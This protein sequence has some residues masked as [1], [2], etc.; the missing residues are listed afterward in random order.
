[1][2]RTEPR[3][4]TNLDQY[5][6]ETLPWSRAL[7]ALEESPG[8]PGRPWFLG[9]TDA[10]GSPHAAGVGAMWSDGGLYFVSG[11]RTRK[12]RD[13]AARPAATLSGS[14]N[15]ID[16]VFEG[17]ARRVTDVP[18]LERIARVYREE[19]GWPVEVE[20]QAFTAPYT[21]PSGGPPPWY[22]YQ[23]EYNTVYGVSTAEPWGATR[24]RFR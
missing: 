18:T 22:L 20:G 17:S 8:G 10:D 9:V 4:T 14:L 2:A 24:W 13:L 5:G 11:P 19:G 6:G 3:E 16:L 12:S 15:G 21:A 23:L 1:M 7:S